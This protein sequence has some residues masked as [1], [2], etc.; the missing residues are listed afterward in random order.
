MSGWS[1]L[2]HKSE[3]VTK[4]VIELLQISSQ[5]SVEVAGPHEQ[6]GVVDVLKTLTQDRVLQ[7]ELEQSR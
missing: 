1:N 7:R 6:N 4:W 3:F 2:S 5:E